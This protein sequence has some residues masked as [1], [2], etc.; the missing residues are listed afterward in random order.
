MEV[1]SHRWWSVTLANIWVLQNELPVQIRIQKVQ[2]F[3]GFYPQLRGREHNPFDFGWWC[4]SA[5]SLPF[6]G[7]AMSGPSA[8]Q[9]SPLPLLSQQTNS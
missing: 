2:K 1:Y 3:I 6:E 5:S 9:V 7:A 4:S 8:S